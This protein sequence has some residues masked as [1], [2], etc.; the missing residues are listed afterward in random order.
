MRESIFSR[1]T[2]ETEITVGLNLDQQGENKLATGI[3]FFDHML[4][5]FAF[6]AGITLNVSCKGDLEVDGHHTVEDVGIC[7]GQAFAKILGDKKGINRY[8]E[9]TL[10]M[11]EALANIVLDFSGRPF[12][13]FN[14]EFSSGYRCGDFEVELVEEFFR[15]LATNCGL[16]LHINLLY[17]KNNHHIIEAI[18]KA[19]GC[20]VKQAI[21][22]TGD[23]ISSTKGVL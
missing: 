22:I 18:F 12:V 16:T 3:G 17:G 15:A 10:P 9:A 20:A 2:N 1:K 21:K 14:A 23:T 13:V 7:I 8:G 5:M 11:D 19:F 6:R 4:N